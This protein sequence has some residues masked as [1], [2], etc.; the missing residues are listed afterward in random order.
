MADVAAGNEE[1]VEAWNGVLFE[2]FLRYRDVIG[3]GVGPLGDAALRLHPPAPGQRVLDVGCG[4]GDTTRQ[5]AEL[6]GPAGSVVGVDVGEGFLELARREASERGLANVE[7]VLADVQVA[8]LGRAF[9]FAF[10]RLGTMF[11]ADPVTAFGN[12]RRALVP[13]GR[14]CM[15]VWRR[16]PDNRWVHEAERIVERF[17]PRE[18]PPGDPSARPGPYSMADADVSTDILRGAG[19]EQVSLRR[20]D[21]SIEIGADLEQA[22]EFSMA[23]GPAGEAIRL[24]GRRAA[25]L[26]PRIAAAL[27]EGLAEFARPGGVR[28]PA[29]AWIVSA[30]A[31]GG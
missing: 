24:A 14:L 5:I 19:F 10:S 6:V 20:C 18:E 8:E 16:K 28:A 21:L 15:V 4:F 13:G 11:F 31:P 27:R 22:V 17:L 9:D 30:R 26:R 1:T 2:R 7:Y 29:S 3:E 23:L 12:V 25:R